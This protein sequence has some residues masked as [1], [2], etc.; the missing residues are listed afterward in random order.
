MKVKRNLNI[1]TSLLKTLWF[2]AINIYCVTCF[3]QDLEY[4]LV[5]KGQNFQLDDRTQ[6]NLTKNTSFDFKNNFE[7]SFDLKFNKK[8]IAP[9]ESFFIFSRQGG[10]IVNKKR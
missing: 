8:K 10:F 1:D 7:L 9:T 2:V 3:S 4:G 6:L 5:F